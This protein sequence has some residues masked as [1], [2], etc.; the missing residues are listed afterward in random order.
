MKKWEVGFPRIT[1]EIYV[2]EAETRD[3]AWKKAKERF[4]KETGDSPY[5]LE[6]S[7]CSEKEVNKK[8]V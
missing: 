1:Y 5:E 3:E 6:G 2:I 4:E 8:I 7:W